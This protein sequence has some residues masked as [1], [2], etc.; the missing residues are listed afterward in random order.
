MVLTYNTGRPIEIYKS[1]NAA[2]DADNFVVADMS[3]QNS[4]S[5]PNST[6]KYGQAVVLRISGDMAM[7][8][9]VEVFSHQDT[10][11]NYSGRHYF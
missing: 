10:L 9:N 11:F 3:F 5:T 6:N 8:Y 1:A 4:E 2:V 7:F